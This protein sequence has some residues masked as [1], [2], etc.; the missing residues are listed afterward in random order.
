MIQAAEETFVPGSETISLVQKPC[1]FVFQ[2]HP[3]AYLIQSSLALPLPR[4]PS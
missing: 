1:D 4:P 3:C 2:E